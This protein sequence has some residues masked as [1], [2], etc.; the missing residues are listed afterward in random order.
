M[1]GLGD[2][3]IVKKKK[4]QKRTIA[5]LEMNEAQD[6]EVRYIKGEVV[7]RGELAKGVDIGDTVLYDKNAASGVDS[8]TDDGDLLYV[9]RIG[10][11]AYK[12]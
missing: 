12:L 7:M 8:N 5:G 10:H 3:V 11:C 2:Y 6:K 4:G 9:I 1:E